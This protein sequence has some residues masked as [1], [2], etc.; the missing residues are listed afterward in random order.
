RVRVDHVEDVAAA[1]FDEVEAWLFNRKVSVAHFGGARIWLVDGQVVT[2]HNDRL[3]LNDF[4][5]LGWLETW[6]PLPEGCCGKCPPI[7]S[8]GYDCTCFGNPNCG[9]TG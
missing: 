9:V 7:L 5:D 2:S 1:P 3:A 8:G 6:E 4:D